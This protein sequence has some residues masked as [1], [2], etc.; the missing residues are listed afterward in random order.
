MFAPQ[1]AFADA[2][3]VAEDPVAVL[4]GFA[5]SDFVFCSCLDGLSIERLSSGSA[6]TISQKI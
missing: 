1:P 5:L 6:G 4:G 3:E 2:F